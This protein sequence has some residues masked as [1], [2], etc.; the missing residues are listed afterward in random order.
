MGIKSYL[1][2]CFSGTCECQ[3]VHCMVVSEN[4]ESNYYLSTPTR[5]RERRTRVSTVVG[6]I[7]DPLAAGSTDRVDRRISQLQVPYAG[8]SANS[9]YNR[10]VCGWV[11]IYTKRSGW[12]V[13]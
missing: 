7:Q 10:Q 11:I 12:A 13:N 6:Y 5:T 9:L 2:R 1:S 3:D 8:G 4:Y